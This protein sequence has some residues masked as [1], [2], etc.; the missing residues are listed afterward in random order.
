MTT[1]DVPA[2]K[3]C[4]RPHVERR[5]GTQACT[6]HKHD[7]AGCSKPPLAGQRVCGTHGGQS[8]QALTAAKKV[9]AERKAAAVIQQLIPD[10]V[11]PIRDPIAVLARL[12]GEA[13]AVRG[14]IAKK[15]NQLADL[16]KKDPAV[17]EAIDG[18]MP[19]Y[20]RAFDRTA[21]TCEALVR[22]NYLERHAAIEEAQIAALLAVVHR[23]LELIPDVALR[24]IITAEI[25]DGLKKL[26]IAS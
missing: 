1:T 12:A 21:R 10:Q 17:L 2:C 8:P 20:E 9:V 6:S 13:D 5:W 25:G 23:G 22:S 15:I 26:P 14:I 16:K 3:Q 11:D 7:G 4:G 24:R 18:F 19:H